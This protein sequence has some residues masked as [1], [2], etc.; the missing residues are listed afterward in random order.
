MICTFTQYAVV[1]LYRADLEGA[2]APVVA[3]LKNWRD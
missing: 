1:I 3:A 2:L